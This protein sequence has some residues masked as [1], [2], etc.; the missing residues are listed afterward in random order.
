METLPIDI[1][2]K[3]LEYDG[4]IKYRNG[5]YIN[6][7]NKSDDIYEILLTIQIPIFSTRFGVQRSEVS[8]TTSKYDK[9]DLMVCRN[10]LTGDIAMRYHKFKHGFVYEVFTIKE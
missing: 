4:R 7:I 6:Q 10:S 1:V 3:I 2:N 9:Y 8:F 5:K